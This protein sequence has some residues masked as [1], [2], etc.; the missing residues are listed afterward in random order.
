[1]LYTLVVIDSFIIE[2]VNK[3]FM[4]AFGEEE[5]DVRK[6]VIS[7]VLVLGGPWNVW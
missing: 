5:K 1:M 7:F 2:N 4:G 3:Q 6:S